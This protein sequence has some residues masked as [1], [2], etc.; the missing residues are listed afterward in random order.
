MNPCP[1]GFQGSDRCRCTPDQIRRYRDKIS[2]PLLDRIDLQ[3]DV[4]NIPSDK[5]VEGKT[6]GDSS[7]TVYQR[8][9]TARQ[10]QLGRAGKIN[11][12]MSSREVVKYCVLSEPQKALLHR[13]ITQLGLSARA[14]HRIL[15]VTRTIADLDD[16]ATLNIDHLTEALGYRITL[17]R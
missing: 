9:Q 5:L 8:V 1:C 15:K 13:A 10:R 3:V 16:S 7:N 4:P 12:K 6:D 14:F 2:G 17:S 11:A